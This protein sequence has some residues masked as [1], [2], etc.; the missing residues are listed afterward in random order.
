MRAYKAEQRALKKARGCIEC[1]RGDP[2]NCAAQTH[3]VRVTSLSHA[4]MCFA[5]ARA[6]GGGPGG[7]GTE[8][9]N[10]KGAANDAV[11]PPQAHL[12][13][14]RPAAG[15]VGIRR[16]RPAAEAAGDGSSRV[17][18][19]AT[20]RGRRHRV[21]HGPARKAADGGCGGRPVRAAAP[22]RAVVVAAA[23][24]RS[25]KRRG[26]D[27]E[28]PRLRGRLR[29]AACRR[30]DASSPAERRR[31]RWSHPPRERRKRRPPRRRV[32]GPR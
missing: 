31:T 14:R 15:P 2:G 1:I 21:K 4:P 30:L 20:K 19:G 25:R 6:G 12:A 29:P 23:E 13:H 17:A 3:R 32:P 9:P 5:H 22:A 16:G 8:E 26:G 11:R 18:V 27:G 24:E 28:A 10:P 7:S